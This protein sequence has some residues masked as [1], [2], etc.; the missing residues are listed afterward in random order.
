MIESIVPAA[1]SYAWEIDS[2]F[3]L[4]FVLTGFWFILCEGVFFWL[5]FKFKAKDGQ[6][7]N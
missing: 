6:P 5:I 7:A 1:S 3:T 2:I 4:I